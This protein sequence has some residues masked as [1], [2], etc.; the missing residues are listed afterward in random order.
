MA[1][2]SLGNAQIMHQKQVVKAS[3]MQ[4]PQAKAPSSVS[5]GPKLGCRTQALRMRRAG[6]VSAPRQTP[7]I[8]AA[9][10]SKGYKVRCHIFHTAICSGDSCNQLVNL[11]AFV[12]NKCAGVNCKICRAVTPKTSD[13]R[14]LV[15]HNPC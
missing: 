2:F 13:R 12:S 4:L 7:L 9:A 6:A 10:G 8:V 5:F 3:L 15:E 14:Q 1:S 11:N